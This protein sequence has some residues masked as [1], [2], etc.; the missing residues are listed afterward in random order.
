[1]QVYLPVAEMS[2]DVLEIL[3]LGALTGFLSGLFGVGGGFLTTPLLIFIGIPP[4][5]AT[6]TQANQLVGSSVSGVISQ[7]RRGA[8]DFK[9][10]GMLTA[11]GLAG[12]LIGVG[13][14]SLLRRLGQV[15]LA[16]SLIYVLVLG[17]IGSLMA[18]ESLRAVL[19]TRRQATR[20][21]LHQHHWM[22]GLPLKMRFPRSRLY[23]SA[24]VPLAIG[25]IGGLLTSIMG[26]GGG[27]FLVPAMIYLLGMPTAMV[28]GTSLFQIIFTTAAVTI[29]QAVSNRTVDLMLAVL[30]LAG[31]V[32]GAQYGSRLGTRLKGEHTRLLLALLVLGVAAKLLIDLVIQPG[33]RY[34][35]G[36]ARPL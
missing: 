35:F 6:A 36:L 13:L 20:R 1:M 22:H 34:S 26:V 14:V 25:L 32:I 3:L 16:I 5:V 28:A 8:V 29:L 17:T 21:K 9:M 30:L 4:T 10:G 18:V 33:E 11:G 15:D 12:S 23:I 2:V 7:W 27:F 24:I 31:G 19:Q